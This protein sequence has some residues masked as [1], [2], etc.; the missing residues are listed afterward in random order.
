MFLPEWRGLDSA[1]RPP[2]GPL[3]WPEERVQGGL[4]R[5]VVAWEE[6]KT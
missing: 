5:T 1:N 2:P 4:G 3:P 6:Q